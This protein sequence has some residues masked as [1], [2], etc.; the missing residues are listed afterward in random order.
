M[1]GLEHY[2]RELDEIVH[3]I[4][5]SADLCGLQLLEPGVLDAVLRKDTS[6]CSHDNPIAFEKLRG[7]LVLA[8]KVIDEAVAL[9][10][11]AATDE[12]LRAAILH[13]EQLRRLGR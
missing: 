6:L 9:N 13:V 4:A 8:Y 10:G 12:A 2:G 11:A 5:L 3:E 1:S 7:L